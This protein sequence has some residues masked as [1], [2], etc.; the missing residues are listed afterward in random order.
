MHLAHSTSDGN[1]AYLFERDW[2]NAFK[3]VIE[4]IDGEYFLWLDD[5]RMD[6]DCEAYQAF[7]ERYENAHTVVDDF[8]NLVKPDY[9]T[10]MELVRYFGVHRGAEIFNDKTR[11]WVSTYTIERQLERSQQVAA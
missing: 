3:L 9:M 2:G 1:E 4:R 5:Y 8:G 10:L 6:T 11:M 7:R